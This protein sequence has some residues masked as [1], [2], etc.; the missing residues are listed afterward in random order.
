MCILSIYNINWEPSKVYNKC[1]NKDQDITLG[2]SR[3]DTESSIQALES[4]GDGVSWIE[5]FFI[6]LISLFVLLE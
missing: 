2:K 1:T 3:Y 4:K 5:I 6:V